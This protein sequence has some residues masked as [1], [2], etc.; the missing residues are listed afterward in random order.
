MKNF[1]ISEIVETTTSQFTRTVSC[2]LSIES[3]DAGQS[4]FTVSVGAVKYG[5][6]DWSEPR[7]HCPNS[8]LFSAK[9]FDILAIAVAGLFKVYNERWPS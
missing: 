5:E 6:M 4:E 7:F 9:Q 1:Q 3:G 8:L 2:G